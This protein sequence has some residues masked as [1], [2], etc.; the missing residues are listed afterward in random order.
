M[1]Q[2]KRCLLCDGDLIFVQVFRNFPVYMGV[3]DKTEQELFSDMEFCSCD[4]CGCVQLKNLIEPSVLYNRPH[5]PAIGKT[6]ETHNRC[7]SD[8]VISNTVDSSK[9]LDVGGANMKI[10]NLVCESSKV[11]SYTVCD[12]SVGSYT[13]EPNKKIRTIKGYVEYLSTE[14]KY[15]AI[16]L[17]HTLEHF[18]EPVAVM[19]KLNELLSDGGSV[20]ISIPNIEAQ[21]EDGFLNALNFEHTYYLSHEYMKLLASICG[22]DVVHTENFSKYNSF[23]RLQKKQ[24]GFVF[25][26]DTTRSRLVYQQHIQ[27]LL[28]DVAEI[29]FKID[30]KQVYCFGAHVFTQMMI[31]AGLNT[32]AIKGLLDNDTGKIGKFLYGYDLPVLNPSIIKEESEPIVLLR[33]AQYKQE[34]QEGL[35]AHNYRVKFI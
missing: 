20:F 22:F 26:S 28:K 10:G 30:G 34:I 15:D 13:L 24:I 6:W 3:T 16:V 23:Y 17:S 31:A 5:N 19:K 2:R 25:P 29:N 21:L 18:Y 32:S 35:L 9:I 27:K 7:L 33:V 8:Y 14:E 1:I 11:Q 4:N 12:M